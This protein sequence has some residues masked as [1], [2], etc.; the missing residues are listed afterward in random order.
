[1]GERITGKFI[2]K[3]INLPLA[4][5]YYGNK[6]GLVDDY[7]NNSGIDLI[8][9]IDQKKYIK[10]TIKNTRI[11]SIFT[12]HEIWEKLMK[13]PLQPIFCDD[14]RFYF[15]SLYNYISRANYKNEPTNIADSANVHPR[16]YVSEHNVV[17]GKNTIIEPN[18]TILSD[19]EIGNNVI[20]RAG[21][22]IGSEGFEHKRTT[23]G[24]LSVFH[25]G[26]VII[27]DNVEI[28]ANTCIDKGFIKN[29]IIEG[30]VKID[31][32]VHIGHSVTIGK[33]SL[34]T[35]GVIIAGS[36]EIGDNVWLS[37]GVTVLNNIFIGSNSFVGIHS[38]VIRNVKENA[39]V[40]GTPAIS[41]NPE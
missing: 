3:I 40:F 28:G 23:K 9:F 38:V 33:K 21:A 15:Y 32:L 39:I 20:I 22:V 26:K 5:G 12:T 25:N 31:N 34:I 1:M 37:P 14:P 2:R 24:V 19:V 36:V 30:E 18:A 4:E 16:S 11:R 35:A 17:I 8:T 41:L 7:S 29:T 6:L 10:N 27:H 13:V